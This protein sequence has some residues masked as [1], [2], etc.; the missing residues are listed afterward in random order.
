MG[1]ILSIASAAAPWSLALLGL[2]LPAVTGGL[3]TVSAI[4]GA[5]PRRKNFGPFVQR[6]MQEFEDQCAG[7]VRG[8]SAADIE[9]IQTRLEEILSRP[10]DVGLLLGPA[11]FGEQQFQAAL[12]GDGRVYDGLGDD[13]R[14]YLDAIVSRIHG[15]VLRFAQ[16]QEV[17]GLAGT[18]A[19]RL[20]HQRVAALESSDQATS[21]IR[22]WHSR[23]LIMGTRPALA[24]GFVARDELQALRDSLAADGVASVCAVRGMRGVGK[25]QLA[26]AF[27]Q[28]CENAGWRFVGW[29][30]ASSREQAIAELASMA[31][32]ALVSDDDDPAAAE[33][34]LIVW[35]NGGGPGERLLVLDN[36]ERVDDIR[37]L[38]PRGPGMRVIITTNSRTATVGIP[39][40]LGVFTSQQAVDYLNEVTRHTDRSGAAELAEDLGRLPVALTQAGAAINLL[41]LSYA[42]YRELLTQRALDDV[43]SQDPGDPYPEKVGT[44]LR[45]AYSAQLER[46]GADNPSIAETAAW[47]LGALCFLAE[48]GVPR[49]WLTSLLKTP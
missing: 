41:N 18:A 20:L 29:V 33:Q 36:V 32:V 47:V 27:A 22:E 43:V 42:D 13:G 34:A 17:F 26:S 40:D 45:I 9:A 11:L 46:M 14:G 10:P 4:V 25:S 48:S 8:A 30:R 44:A 23:T 5:F 7:E 28:E 16:S 21:L 1:K 37:E 35:L 12:V 2:P 3:S 38:I 15:L 19:I 6:A 24:A 49:S 31:D 39:V